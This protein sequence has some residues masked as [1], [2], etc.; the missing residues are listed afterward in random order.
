VKQE[1][2][3][4]HGKEKVQ[5]TDCEAG[6]GLARSWPRLPWGLARIL[7]NPVNPYHCQNPA[8]NVPE[9]Q[10]IALKKHLIS[11]PRRYI[12]SVK[13]AREIRP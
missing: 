10:Q 6:S 12:L 1:I 5:E 3:L 9:T 8:A 4:F 2:G 13:S 7:D 11:F